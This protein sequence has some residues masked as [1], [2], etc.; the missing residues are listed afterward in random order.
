M[1]NESQS[2]N[3]VVLL[4]Q[5]KYFSMPE[6]HLQNNQSRDP[7]PWFRGTKNARAQGQLFLERISK[8]FHISPKIN[9]VGFFTA[10]TSVLVAFS[11]CAK[12]P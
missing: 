12:T 1:V 8:V 7:F 3:Q 11:F 4:A 9:R 10:T 5:C 6:Y 2:P